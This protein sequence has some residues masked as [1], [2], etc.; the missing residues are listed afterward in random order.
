MNKMRGIAAIAAGTFIALGFAATG[1]AA[2]QIYS[3]G[4]S[5]I[6]NVDG[7]AIHNEGVA[8]SGGVHR[9]AAEYRDRG[10]SA[11][12]YFYCRVA[13]KATYHLEA[14]VRPSGY[15]WF[16]V[17]GPDGAPQVLWTGARPTAKASAA[18]AMEAAFESGTGA[19][20]GDVYPP[21]YSNYQPGK[22]YSCVNAPTV[23]CA[24]TKCE[25]ERH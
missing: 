12:A 13:D 5:H 4:H 22:P 23:Q 16:A 7:V 20:A 18:R 2:A 1:D 17:V 14:A 8:L 11:W 3:T 10:L 19:R 24:S 9:I 25:A 6:R 21:D 15:L